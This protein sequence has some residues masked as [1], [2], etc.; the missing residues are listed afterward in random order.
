MWTK[1][2]RRTSPCYQKADT[3]VDVTCFL[4]IKRL[5]QQ[6]IVEVKSWSTTG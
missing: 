4:I 6:E 2:R 3:P 1:E 5:L